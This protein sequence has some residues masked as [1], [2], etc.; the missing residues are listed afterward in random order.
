VEEKPKTTQQKAGAPAGAPPPMFGNLIASK[1]K[2]SKG[3]IAS[4]GL[5]IAIHA[6]IIVGLVYATAH[7]AAAPP[8]EDEPVLIQLAPEEP[9]PPPPPP[10]KLD[11][12]PPPTTAEPVAKG[13]QTLAVPD[14]V[15]PDIPP[16]QVGVVIREEDFSAKGVAGGKADGKEGGKVTNDLA[17]APFVTPMTVVPKILNSRDVET[18]ISRNYPAM[19]RD[20]GIGGKTVMWFFIDENGRSVKHQVNQSSGYAALDSAAAKVAPVL[21]FTA[22][23]NQGKKVPVWVQIPIVFTVR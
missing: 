4:T 22:A 18:A 19:L 8:K 11:V 1:P 16:P 17:A 15:P 6:A 14:V 13:F 3:G 5:S 10:P 9:P 21:R 7:A 12:P 20:A 23:E 2:S